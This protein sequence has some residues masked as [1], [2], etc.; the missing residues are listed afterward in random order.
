[1]YNYYT[2]VSLKES[3]RIILLILF[4]LEAEYILYLYTST[5]LSRVWKPEEMPQ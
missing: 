2:Y 5:K 4:Q 1:M 3:E